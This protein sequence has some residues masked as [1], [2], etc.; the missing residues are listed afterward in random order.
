MEYIVHKPGYVLV[1]IYNLFNQEGVLLFQTSD[2]NPVWR[3]S[4][5]HPGRYKSTVRIPGNFLAE[6]TVIVSAAIGT[7]DSFVLHVHERDAVAFQVVDSMEGNS[8]RGDYGGSIPGV[9]RPLLNWT[10]EYD[11]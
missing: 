8:A 1:P 5:R 6:G 10:D 4:A 9:I 7:M 2:Q 11:G 3:H